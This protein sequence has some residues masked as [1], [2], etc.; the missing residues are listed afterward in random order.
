MAKKIK[1]SY[2][3]ILLFL[4]LAS[5]DK[6]FDALN[7][8]PIALTSVTPDYQ[9]NNTIVNSSFG[10]TQIY[11]GTSIVK[12][13]SR[14]FSGAGALGNFNVDVRETSSDYWNTGYQNVRDLVDAM[15]KVKDDPASTNLYSMLRIWRAYIL[16]IITD[17]YGDVP[18][19][20]AGRGYLNGIVKP[21]YDAQK[22]IYTDILNELETAS[23]ALDVSKHESATA[24]DI[25]YGSDI[26]KWKRLGYSLLL[27]AAMRLSKVSPDIAKKYV[28]VAVS[29]GLMQSN[30]DNVI[31]PHT[32]NFPNSAGAQLNGGQ[33]YYQYLV[34]DFVDYL[35]KNVDP[36]LAS[37]AVR[38]VGAANIAGQKEA[39]ADRS[40]KDQIGLPMGYDNTTIGPVAAAAGLASFYAYSQL[41]RTRMGSPSA[42]T[43]LITY[44]QTQLLLAEAVFRGWA[45]GDVN[46]LYSTGV[47]ADMERFASYGSNTAI[48]ESDIDTYITINPLKA[49]E[50]LQQINT[51]YWVAS[52]LMGPEA[53]ANF[54]RS[55]YPNLTPN[56]LRGDLSPGENFMRRFGY[57][58]SELVVNRENVDKAISRQGPDNISTRV[59]WDVK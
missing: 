35:K 15:S 45:N 28:A 43:F 55:G 52:F 19:T 12:Q 8:S 29:G 40:P 10:L 57:P 23:S 1:N 42:P 58:Q 16:M 48:S 31:I 51:Q 34:E 4:I 46:A 9:L 2:I 50:E 20:D 56:P 18:Y 25:L 47:R 17:S 59:W 30:D 7:T 11:G 36:R 54:R 6:G 14:I 3:V 32:A 41:D 27:R 39:N 21:S 33:S 44:T 38:Y 37:I 49:G 22:T 26:S 13:M 24:S 5:C 53:W